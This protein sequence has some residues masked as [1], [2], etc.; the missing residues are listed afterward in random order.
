M[1]K[2]TFT[3]SATA[4]LSAAAS[5]ATMQADLSSSSLRGGRC[6][7][8]GKIAYPRRMACRDCGSPLEDV[9]LSGRAKLHSW[10]TIRTAPSGFEAPY[11]LG[12]AV[13]EEGPRLLVRIEKPQRQL[14][15]GAPLTLR[16]YGD[17]AEDSR[18]QSLVAIARAADTEGVLADA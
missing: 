3:G 16:R 14:K 12:Y 17:E 9:A 5:V 2:R 8:C 11:V 1:S 10:T 15:I 4:A 18:G 7:R 13:M 6:T